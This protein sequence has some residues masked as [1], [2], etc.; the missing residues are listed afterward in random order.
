MYKQT[1][2]VFFL[3]S[4][5]WLIYKFQIEER[6][7]LKKRHKQK[8]LEFGESLR[9]QVLNEPLQ[10]QVDY[11]SIHSV[12]VFPGIEISNKEIIASRLQR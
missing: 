3:I 11:Q 1:D 2:G 5:S 4:L 10:E 6:E 12:T 7:E 9:D 8:E